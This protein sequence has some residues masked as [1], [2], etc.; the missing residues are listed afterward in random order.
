[1]KRAYMDK[2]KPIPRWTPPNPNESALQHFRKEEQKR[3]AREYQREYRQ[4]IRRREK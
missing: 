1:M 2:N 4:G 3:K